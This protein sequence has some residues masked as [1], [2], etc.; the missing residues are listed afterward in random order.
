LPESQAKDKNMKK[1]KE[2]EGSDGQKK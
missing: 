1:K 2:E